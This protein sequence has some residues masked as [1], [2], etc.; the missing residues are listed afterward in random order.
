MNRLADVIFRGKLHYPRWA[1]RSKDHIKMHPKDLEQ[2]AWEKLT[3]AAI[4]EASNVCEFF[5]AGSD[6]EVWT[7]SKDFPNL[8]P[9]FPIFWIEMHRPSRIVSDL[10]GEL[11]S[12]KALPFRSGFLFEASPINQAWQMLTATTPG[13]TLDS[14]KAHLERL[15]QKSGDGWRNMRELYG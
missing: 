7:V 11:D 8:A 13:V 6:Q 5:Y 1:T 4:I 2:F 3:Q 12:T 10:N 9:P 14:A 15:M